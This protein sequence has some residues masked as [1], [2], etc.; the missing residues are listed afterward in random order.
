MLGCDGVGDGER[1]PGR[2]REGARSDVSAGSHGVHA[3][4]DGDTLDILAV[5]LHAFQQL[6]SALDGGTEEISLEIG[7]SRV[8]EEGGR[9]VSVGRDVSLSKI[10]CH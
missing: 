8:I 4:R 6:H 7:V 2:G 1:K 5:L 9:G 3:A 10:E